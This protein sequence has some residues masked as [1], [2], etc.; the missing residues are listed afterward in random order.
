MLA[1]L[2]AFLAA[3]LALGARGPWVLAFSGGGDSTALALGLAEVAP[4]HA[5][6][7]HLFHVDHAL[8]PGSGERAAGAAAIAAQIGLPF[9]AELHPVPEAARRREGTEAAARRVRYAALE[10]FGCGSAPTGSHCPP[11]RRPDRDPAPA[12]RRRQQPR[13]P[14]R[15]PAP[16]RHLC[17]RC[18]TSTARRS[19]PLS[20]QGASSRSPI[21]QPR[22]RERSQSRSPPPPSLSSGAG[23]W[24]GRCYGGSRCGGRASSQRSRQPDRE[25][26]G[27]GRWGIATSPRDRNASLFTGAFAFFRLDL[28]E[29]WA[30]GKWPDRG[31]R[32]ASGCANFRRRRPE[33]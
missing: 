12:H 11:P 29:R 10:A 32:S 21:P 23:A 13:R 27:K 18:S 22:P 4:R 15:N 25:A 19:T 33:R 31:D 17:G 9:T 5:L 2:D 16:P 20:P 8:D 14:R 3:E 1:T 7:V 26:A 6:A 24:T 30:G 28:L